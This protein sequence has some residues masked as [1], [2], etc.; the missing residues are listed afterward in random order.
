MKRTHR[1]SLKYDSALNLADLEGDSSQQVFDLLVEAASDGD[2][3][4]LYALSTWQI[5]G[6]QD[7]VP[8]D[9]KKAFLNLK[10]LSTSFVAEAL[11]DLAYSYDIGHGTKADESK[12]FST[13]MRAALMGSK[14]ANAQVAE[15]Y[16]EGKIV[17]RDSNISLEWRRR[18]RCD[19]LE[20]SPPYRVWLRDPF[21]RVDD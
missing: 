18:S 19:E 10:K 4:A 21:K 15:F 2:D 20:I 17:S 9:P 3:R 5:W 12:A 1:P 13:Y 14:E 8:K 16:R 11:F 6:E 7:V